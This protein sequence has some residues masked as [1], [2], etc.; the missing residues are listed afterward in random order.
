[1]KM[2]KKS[3]SKLEEVAEVHS[4]S[5]EYDILIKQW[6]HSI[7]ELN[8]LMNSK[9]RSVEGVEDPVESDYS[10]VKLKVPNKK[11]KKL[12]PADMADIVDRLGLNESL[13]ILNSLDDELDEDTLE[14]VSPERQVSILEGMDGKRA[15]EI[16]DEMSPDDATDV[17]ADLS[18]RKS[19]RTFRPYGTGR[20]Q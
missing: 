13:N 8:Q 5:G 20:I 18:R 7:E 4:V 17:L 3:Y 15:A 16:L 1:M 11:I 10:K 9:I 6:G 12:H 19:R 2:S 14:E